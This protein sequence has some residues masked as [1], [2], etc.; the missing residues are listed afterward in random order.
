MD[1]PIDKLTNKTMQCNKCQKEMKLVPAGVSKRTGKKYDAF[2]SC[3]RECGETAKAG[4][5]YTPPETAPEDKVQEMAER[6][7]NIETI[8]IGKTLSVKDID[9]NI[10]NLHQRLDKLAEWIKANVK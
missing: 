10:D 7:L 1:G 8:L 9:N 6:I 5:V 2:Y 3:D 4:Q